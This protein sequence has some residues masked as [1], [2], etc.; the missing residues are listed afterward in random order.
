MQGKDEMRRVRIIPEH[1]RSY[2]NTFG[3]VAWFLCLRLLL[4]LAAFY[5]SAVAIDDMLRLHH[6]YRKLKET[7]AET[8]HQVST[9]TSVRLVNYVIDLVEAPSMMVQ[10]LIP[11]QVKSF[12]LLVVVLLLA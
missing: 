2:E 1:D 7:G 11:I 6:I 12:W 5:T 10:S 4:P 9:R 8:P 3:S